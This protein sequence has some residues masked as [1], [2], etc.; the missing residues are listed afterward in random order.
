MCERGLISSSEG[1]VPPGSFF[2][3]GPP[4]AAQTMSNPYLS[5]FPEG[6]DPDKLEACCA[7]SRM[8]NHLDSAHFEPLLADNVEFHSQLVL[9]ALEGKEAYLHY[10]RSKMRLWEDQE[11]TAQLAYTPMGGVG[12]CVIF[13]SGVQ[14][15]HVTVCFTVEDGLVVEL[16]YCVV[17]HPTE[18]HATG[19][20][21]RERSD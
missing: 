12:P 17:P 6:T 7:F 3:P 10:I 2:F 4:A 15:R 9:E 21:P 16:C 14:D 5:L 1:S 13:S 20:Y 11:V 19:E 18:C 8:I